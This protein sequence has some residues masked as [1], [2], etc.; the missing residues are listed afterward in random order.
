MIPGLLMNMSPGKCPR[1][2]LPSQ[3]HKTPALTKT[4]PIMMRAFCMLC[5]CSLPLDGRQRGYLAARYGAAA[6]GTV[7]RG[8]RPGD[9]RLSKTKCRQ[10]DEPTPLHRTPFPPPEHKTRCAPST[11]PRCRPCTFRPCRHQSHGDK[12]D[13]GSCILL[14]LGFPSYSPLPRRRAIHTPTFPGHLDPCRW[15]QL[16]WQWLVFLAMNITIFRVGCQRRCGV[17]HPPRSKARP[18][19][20]SAP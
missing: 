18:Q 17:G 10:P 9:P 19:S 15:P 7:G 2:I 16:R 8:F 4:M 5:N 11:H 12:F 1:G 6:S 20:D 14:N 13:P 3:G